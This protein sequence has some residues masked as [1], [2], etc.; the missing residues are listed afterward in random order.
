MPGAIVECVVE[1]VDTDDD[2]SAR[3]ERVTL[4]AAAPNGQRVRALPVLSGIA[5]G[6]YG[7]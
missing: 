1:S 5:Q 7:R 6:S 3:L 2:F 4:P